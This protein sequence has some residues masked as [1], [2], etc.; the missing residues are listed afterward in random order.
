MFAQDR[1]L[2]ILDP[3]LFRD[4]VILGQRLAIGNA[5]I[6]A[7][8]L[9]MTGIDFAALGITAGHVVIFDGAA[10]EITARLSSTTLTVSRPRASTSAAVIPPAT[11][12][13][14]PMF[15][16]TFA[17][18]IALAHD[19]LI[20]FAGLTPA[21]E[22][23]TDD[24]PAESTI[25]NPAALITLETLTALASIYSALAGLT[26]ATS[27]AAQRAEHFRRRAAAAR[28]ATAISLDLNADGLQDEVRHLDIIS[29]F[30][31]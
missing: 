11:A 28:A 24:A 7:T 3:S 31:V 21:G 5:S 1:D 2:L 16:A 6:A 22:T 25:L 17:P 29:L 30:R 19:T 23:P 8:T 18:Q 4:G 27:P 13:G 15:I 9:T 26:P 12:T 14:R 20:R 10:L